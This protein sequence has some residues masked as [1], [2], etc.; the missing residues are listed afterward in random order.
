MIKRCTMIGISQVYNIRKK[1]L[2]LKELF[3]ET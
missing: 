3:Q 1:Y 2:T